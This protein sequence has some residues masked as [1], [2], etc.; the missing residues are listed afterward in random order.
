MSLKFSKQIIMRFALCLILCCPVI[1][2]VAAEE[3]TSQTKK[4]TGIS[5]SLT[6]ASVSSVIE[7]IKKETG[8]DFLYNNEYLSQLGHIT[9]NLGSATLQQ[10]FQSVTSQTG[11]E[12]HKM[13][14]NSFI[15]ASPKESAK[16]NASAARVQQDIRVT[17]SVFDNLG[18]LMPGVTINV[19][20]TTIGT[21][22]DAN[23]EYSITAPSDTSVLQF[24]YIGYKMQ[25]IVVGNRR[26]IAV[27]M[28]ESTTELSEVSIVAFGTQKKES[29]IASITT[30]KPSELKVPSSNLTTAFAGRVAGLIS[31]QTSGEPGKDNAS[32]FIRG[33]TSFG[34]ESKKDPLI[35]IDGVELSNE[36]LARLNTDDIATFSIMKDAA[37]TALYGAR[38]GNGVIYVTTKEGREGKI[39]VNARIENS[40]SS[41]TKRIEL[42]DPVTYMRMQNEAVITR[43]PLGQPLYS[44]EKIYMTERGL[45]PE[46][47][48]ATN[49]YETIMKNVATNQRANVSLSGGG[50]IARY[51][52]AANI[53]NDNG[54]IKVDKRNNFNSNISLKKID[55]RSNINLKLTKTTDFGILM[56]AT[57]DDYT[58]PIDGGE[59]IYNKVMQ[60]NPVYFKPY[61]EPDEQFKY[62]KHILFGNYGT[63]NYINPYAEVMKGYREYSRN[64]MNVQ[65]TAKQDLNMITEGLQ[66]RGR[67]NFQRRSEYSVNRNYNP[68]F[69]NISFYNL[70]ENY[71]QLTRMNPEDGT[72]FISYNPGARSIYAYFYLEGV[73]EWQRTLAEKH[74]AGALITY[75][76]SENR[77]ALASDLQLSLPQRNIGVAGRFTY[78]FDKRY[79]AEFDFGYNGSERF[80]IS[81]RW[82]FFPSGVVGWM[83]SNERF[84]EPLK[85]YVNDLKIRASY[86]LSGQ[87]QIGSD[88]DRF[89]FLSQVNLSANRD[90]NWGLNLNYNPKGVE[91]VRYANKDIGWETSYTKNAA[92]ELSLKNGFSMITE[93]FHK[94]TKNILIDRVIPNTMGILPAVKANLGI[95]ENKGIDIELNYEKSFNKDFWA[96]ARGTFTY[97]ASNVIQW[98]EPDY[99][100]TPWRSRVGQ[101][102]DRAWGYIAERLF[103]DDKEVYNSPTQFGIYSA[104]DIKYHDVNGDGRIT[105]LDLV[106]MGYPLSTPEIVF[107]FGPSLGYKGFDLSFFFQGSA[108]KSFFF[109]PS[110]TPFID[111]NPDDGLIGQNAIIKAFADSYWSENNMNPYAM[112]PRLANYVVDNNNR[113]S[114]WFLQDATFIRLKNAEIGY[115]LPEKWLKK[116][117][118]TNFRIYVSGTN[119]ACWSPFKLWDPEMAGN[120]LGYP[121][122]RV[123]NVGINIG[124]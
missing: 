95:G 29:V 114:T 115:K 27:T 118:L 36:D 108:R 31:Y 30:I 98:E 59:A 100:K 39:T 25:E 122:Q 99:S 80:D 97:A 63:G 28:R 4:E 73:L 15:V 79:F 46:I 90:V 38:G 26:S 32:F 3:A 57:F 88:L 51:Y 40:F 5:I 8:Y 84:F 19:R 68:Y 86:G 121:L 113:N 50:N 105:D 34:A 35:L 96:I 104:G 18:N 9:V 45:Y 10:V 110:I 17:G 62:A 42:A 112:W 56:N 116:V 83:I 58:G 82:G 94:R 13:D 49:W 78:N 119:L 20:G 14:D 76:M 53:T 55:V 70:T 72:E 41:P 21:S 103:I 111:S 120:G 48:P 92:L 74:S 43:N 106:P 69:Y 22:T 75:T 93:V 6:D 89:Y 7:A 91:V 24:W 61:Y 101:P 54:N 117:K 67:L 37:A 77:N 52:I 44:S 85:K 64:L 71:Y 107:G 12:F 23:G 2:M 124:L 47:F 109:S 33:I 87:D 16:T 102:I 81:H 65:F 123:I 66:A 60:A 1:S 11:L